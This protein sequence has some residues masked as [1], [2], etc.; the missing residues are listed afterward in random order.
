MGLARSGTTPSATRPASWAPG[1]P[2]VAM[3][4]G[5][6]FS[7][8]SAPMRNSKLGTLYALPSW[9]AR[10]SRRARRRTAT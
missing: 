4:T 9:L 3:Y 6:S 1:P 7:G 5:T 8:S 2:R 10:P